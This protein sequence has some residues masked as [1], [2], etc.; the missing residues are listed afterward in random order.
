[1]NF[2]KEVHNNSFLLLLFTQYLAFTAKYVRKRIF[3][4]SKSHR[5]AIFNGF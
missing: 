5:E 1:M 4:K 2:K 3:Y